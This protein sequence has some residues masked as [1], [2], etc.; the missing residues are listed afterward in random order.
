M[1]TNSAST[2]IGLSASKILPLGMT[3]L[4]GLFIVGFVGFSHLEVV[5][6]AAHDTR[7]SLAF[8]CH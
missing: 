2:A 8:P 6:N 7:H 3:A 5:H 4:L 1:V